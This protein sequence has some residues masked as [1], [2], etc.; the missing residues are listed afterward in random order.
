MDDREERK[1][2]RMLLWQ[3][4]TTTARCKRWQA[5]IADLQRLINDLHDPTKA[6][7]LTGMPGSG[8]ISD[9]TAR[10]AERAI[11][12]SASYMAAADAIAEQIKDAIRMKT[13]MDDAIG[14]LTAIQRRVIELRYQDE[15]S[16]E[17]I[18]LKLTYDESRVRARER[19]AIDHI[20]THIA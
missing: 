12:I 4:A 7:V 6:Q 3:W 13:A 18:A 17:Y 1:R 16:W 20:V 14:G 9:P 8:A 5:E 2:A 11:E 19:E 15:H 10:A